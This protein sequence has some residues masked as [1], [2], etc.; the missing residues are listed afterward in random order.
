VSLIKIFKNYFFLDK[1]KTLVYKKHPNQ[2][3]T[4][5]LIPTYNPSETT[6]KLIKLLKKYTQNS[7][8]IIIDDKTPLNDK[9]K[10]VINKIKK[11]RDNDKNIIYLRNNKNTHK[12][13]ALN[14][15]LRYILNKRKD[16]KQY[17]H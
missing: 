10:V 17:L 5:I 7:Q 9:T 8:I 6:Y 13:G 12:A 11:L 15:G 16:L 2:I 14:C 4:S 3:T 1:K